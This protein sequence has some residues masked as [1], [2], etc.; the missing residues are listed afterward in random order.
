MTVPVASFNNER[1]VQARNA[2]GLTAVS[3]AD[4][5]EVSPSTISL[6]E[7]GSQKP[8]QEVLDRL[9][10][11]LNLP[12]P[13]FLRPVPVKK[14]D[15]LF[16]RSMS[17]ATKAARTRVEAR[18][19]WTV[20]IVSYLL[21]FFDFPR[22]HLP[23]FDGLPDDFRA[24]DPRTIESVADQ[25]RQMW[26]LGHGPI[27]NMVRT[28][29]SN[30]IIVWRTPFEADTLDAFSEFRLPHSIVVLSSDKENYFR[31][32]F[33]VAHELGHLVLHNNVDNK[34]L[35]RSS[36]FKII[37]QQAHHFASAFLMPAVAY[38][39]ELW[40]V[41][42]DA[43]RSLKPRWNASIAVQIMRSSQLEVVD[44][45]QKKRLWIN[46]SRRGWRKR[47][48]LDDS[49]PSEKPNLISQGIRMLIDEHVKTV[50]QLAIDLNLSVSEIERL[51]GL[52]PGSLSAKHRSPA[53][54]SFKI[55][56]QKVVPFKRY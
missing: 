39:K 42:I 35:K 16:Y 52:E 11:V 7:K 56:G 53:Q 28:L 13:F 9:A 19:E 12:P 18:Y 30:G 40:N 2:R 43:F 26:R 27:D 21:E 17:A 45:D 1:L 31:S 36:D 20:E 32:R 23:E 6:Y 4:M 55:S 46:L 25:V 41:S 24:L 15:R 3:L 33:D 22:L 37:E 54:P 51:S 29:E 8:R 10:R 38:S 49:T 48:P 44:E 14:P 50:D 34:T 47:E 5:V